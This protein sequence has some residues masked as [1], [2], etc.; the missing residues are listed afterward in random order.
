[1]LQAILIK[2]II[3]KVMD[4]IEKADDKKIARSLHKRI[5]AL[6]KDSH[7]PQEYICCKKC[8]CKIAKTK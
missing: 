1:M 3:G 5:K 2:T 8:G 7:P 6:E 4:A